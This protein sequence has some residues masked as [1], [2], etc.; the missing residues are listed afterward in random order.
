MIR[1][2]LRLKQSPTLQRFYLDGAAP[3][4]RL[5][6]RSRDALRP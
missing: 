6:A 2:R 3:I 1:L 4:R 5:A